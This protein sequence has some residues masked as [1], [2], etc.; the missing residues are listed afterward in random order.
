MYL[1]SEKFL[2]KKHYQCDVLAVFIWYD[3]AGQE[4]KNDTRYKHFIYTGYGIASI[5]RQEV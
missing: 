2:A 5:T 3:E 1:H 4:I